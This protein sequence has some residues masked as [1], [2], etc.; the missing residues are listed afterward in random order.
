MT[1]MSARINSRTARPAASS[2]ADMTRRPEDR[3]AVDLAR[4]LYTLD[5]FRA[6]FMAIML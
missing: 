6:A 2:A 5:K 3:A 1:A 4:A